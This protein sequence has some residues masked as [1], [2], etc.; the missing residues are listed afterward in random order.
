M[1]LPWRR[2]GNYPNYQKEISRIKHGRISEC[3]CYNEMRGGIQ[4]TKEETTCP[5]SEVA[6]DPATQFCPELA[7]K[8]YLLRTGDLI[9]IPSFMDALAPT[10]ATATTTTTIAAPSARQAE[11]ASEGGC[12][13]CEDAP[14]DS[15][16][17]ISMTQKRVVLAN[18]FAE[19]FVFFLPRE[20]ALHFYCFY[21]FIFSF[22]HFKC[23]I[24]TFS[25]L[26]ILLI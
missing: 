15:V 19:S 14:F 23:T 22:L 21:S 25:L 4:R 24:V 5:S 11:G 9:Q 7:K 8:N 3:A 13:D 20:M 26:Q 16:P 1:F 18:T 6:E 17:D 12:M 10:G 2:D